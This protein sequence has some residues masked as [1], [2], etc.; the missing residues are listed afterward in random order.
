MISS[1]GRSGRRATT[2]SPTRSGAARLRGRAT[3]RAPDGN[4]GDMLSPLIRSGETD[5]RIGGSSYR[6]NWHLEF[7]GVDSPQPYGGGPLRSALWDLRP[8]AGANRGGIRLQHHQE[9]QRLEGRRL[10]AAGDPDQRGAGGAG[11]APS[12][13]SL[14]RLGQAGEA[15]REGPAAQGHSEASHH[16]RPEAESD[17]GSQRG[18]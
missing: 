9:V 14:E 18:P 15:W 12:R 6:R 17:R 7:D 16:A 5:F 8:G 2:M 13:R 3:I 10:P 1:S 4:R 11:E